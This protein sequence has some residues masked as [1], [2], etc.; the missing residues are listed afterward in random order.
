MPKIRKTIRLSVSEADYERFWEAAQKVGGGAA[1]VRRLLSLPESTPDAAAR[2]KR[3]HGGRPAV[4]LTVRMD[5]ADA[6]HLK[7]EAHRMGL[8][9]G[10][11]VVALVRAR[12]YGRLCFGRPND[13]ALAEIQMELR[14]IAVALRHMAHDPKR[15]ETELDPAR[16][17]TFA[18]EVR[19]TLKALQ[20]ALVGNFEYWRADP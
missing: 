4:S 18:A 11:W 2:Q 12:L 7:L 14:R 3:T 17:E 13:I 10:P 1:L 16:L 6:A 8:G 9:M 15:R 5:E 20:A 19:R